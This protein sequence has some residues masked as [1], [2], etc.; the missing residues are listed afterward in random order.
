MSGEESMFRASP[1]L[2]ARPDVLPGM[3][4]RDS[5]ILLTQVESPTKLQPGMWHR[6]SDDVTICLDLPKGRSTVVL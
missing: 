4:V 3:G 5:S 1:V 2:N 6:R